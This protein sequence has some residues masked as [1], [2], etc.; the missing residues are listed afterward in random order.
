MKVNVRATCL[1]CGKEI[2]K[3]FEL[4]YINKS[5]E[6]LKFIQEQEEV[7]EHHHPEINDSFE[8]RFSMNWVV[9]NGIKLI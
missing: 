7:R 2:E 4:E 9:K 1:K 5:A 6:A 3:D 8:W